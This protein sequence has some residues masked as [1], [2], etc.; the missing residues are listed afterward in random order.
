MSDDLVYEPTRQIGGVC[1]AVLPRC[2]SRRTEVC[3]DGRHAHGRTSANWSRNTTPPAERSAIA[4][5]DDLGLAAAD[6]RAREKCGV[7]RYSDLVVGI[8]AEAPA[9]N[10]PD[11]P[12]LIELVE[13]YTAANEIGQRLL[14]N[15]ARFVRERTAPADA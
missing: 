5:Y 15:V 7:S 1:T 8:N 6:A 12:A 11:A 9:E 4:A 14:V 13:A 3:S 10:A 2:A